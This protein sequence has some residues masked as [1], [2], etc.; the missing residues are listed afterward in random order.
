MSSI[1]SISIG[2]LIAVSL[3]LFGPIILIPACWLA[4]N[5]KL[6]FPKANDAN[7]LSVNKFLFSFALM[8]IILKLLLKFF[9]L[10]IYFNF[11]N[12]ISSMQYLDV[13][14]SYNLEGALEKGSFVIPIYQNYIIYVFSIILTLIIT[15]MFVKKI[16]GYQRII[17]ERAYRKKEFSSKNC[18]P[19]MLIYIIFTAPILLFMYSDSQDDSLHVISGLGAMPAAILLPILIISQIHFWALVDRIKQGK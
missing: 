10:E 18:Y 15:V 1:Y 19:I 13:V 16:D 7:F 6:K 3:F 8:G 5:I 4:I 9:P 2:I 14:Y 11:V 12:K 17:I